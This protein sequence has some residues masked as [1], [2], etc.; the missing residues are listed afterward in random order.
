MLGWRLRDVTKTSDTQHIRKNSIKTV[1]DSVL[2]VEPNKVK[3]MP[4][5]WIL[6][7]KEKSIFLAISIDKNFMW[8]EDEEHPW[9]LLPEFE[10]L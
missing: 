3:W 4:L 8:K 2:M 10:H 7:S 6:M 5:E 9:S 1:N